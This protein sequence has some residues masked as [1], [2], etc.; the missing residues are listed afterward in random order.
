MVYIFSVLECKKGVLGRDYGLEFCGEMKLEGWSDGSVK[1]NQ[2]NVSN[3]S[4]NYVKKSVG[5]E[6]MWEGTQKCDSETKSGG[7]IEPNQV[8]GRA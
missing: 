5:V 2:L 1:S 3:Q 8:L 4:T 7:G 6:Y